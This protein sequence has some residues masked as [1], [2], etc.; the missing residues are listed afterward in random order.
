MYCIEFH[1]HLNPNLGPI[2]HEYALGSAYAATCTIPSLPDQPFGSPTDAFGSK[3]AARTN[4]AKEAVEYLIESGDLNP[5]GSTK[6]RKKVKLGTAVRI[7]GKGLEVK[8][9]TTFAQKVQGRIYTPSQDGFH[10]LTIQ[11]SVPF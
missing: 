3:K 1:S 6:G 5:D 11:T 4:A 7:Q 8:K 9:G 2:Y 10:R